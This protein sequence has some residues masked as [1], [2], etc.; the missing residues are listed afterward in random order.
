MSRYAA[1]IANSPA[2]DIGNLAPELHY[3]LDEFLKGVTGSERTQRMIATL[4]KQNFNLTREVTP[5]LTETR[6]VEIITAFAER[7]Q[8]LAVDVF[9]Q[10]HQDGG[11]F[12]E[13]TAEYR[14]YLLVV[15]GA[16]MTTP[17][18]TAKESGKPWR[19][20]DARRLE[21][22]FDLGEFSQAGRFETLMQLLNFAIQAVLKNLIRRYHSEE[23]SVIYQIF[24]TLTGFSN[25]T[26]VSIRAVYEQLKFNKVLSSE[27]AI[28]L[29]LQKPDEYSQIFI[30][31]RAELNLNSNMNPDLQVISISQFYQF[32]RELVKRELAKQ[33]AAD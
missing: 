31:M 27:E 32:L 6:N 24:N 29:F 12:K 14:D 19:Y 7:V 15:F 11:F 2:L 10:L 9:F 23:H 33:E 5:D 16:G 4:R 20:G 18:L 25:L 8:E 3:S 26:M 13:S 21:L 22:I 28:A 30:E 1:P 17:T